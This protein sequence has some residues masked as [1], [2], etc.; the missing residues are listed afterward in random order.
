M[1]FSEAEAREHARHL[2]QGKTLILVHTPDRKEEA[3]S[4]MVKHGAYDESMS[5]SP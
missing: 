5:T 4:I 1:G 2:E 3:R